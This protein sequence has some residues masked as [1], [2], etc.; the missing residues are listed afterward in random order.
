MLINTPNLLTASRIV[1]I[2]AMVGAFYIPGD[3]GKWATCAIF[4]IAAITDYFDGYLA[5]SWSMQS[6][7][8][9]MLD[10]IADKL[11]VGA[12]ILMLV[13]FGRSPILPALVI[14]CREI[15]V[16]GLREFLAEVRIGMP[17]SRL[18]KWKT[19]VQ[20]TAISF[21]LAGSAAP[22]WLFADQVGW[23]G[24]WLAAGLTV[25]TGLDYLVVSLRH[26]AEPAPASAEG[27]SPARPAT[28]P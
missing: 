28:I 3:F 7:L 8:G 18:A 16:S 13:H 25:V 15:L 23:Y 2:P 10:P 22:W 20:M 14:L 5:R 4:T 1:A 6:P 17:V 11:L 27:K 12:A 26:S 21:L 9:R 19:G 24:L